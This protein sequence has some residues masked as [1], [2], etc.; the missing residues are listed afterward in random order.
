MLPAGALGM[1]RPSPLQSAPFDLTSN[2]LFGSGNSMTVEDSEPQED[3]VLL[4]DAVNPSGSTGLPASSTDYCKGWGR[5][6]RALVM[7]I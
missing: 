6:V 3:G 7:P 1:T 5:G 2:H 4:K